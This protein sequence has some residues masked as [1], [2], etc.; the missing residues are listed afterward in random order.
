M[1][2]YVCVLWFNNYSGGR[3]R[4]RKKLRVRGNKVSNPIGI[5]IEK[6]KSPSK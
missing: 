5:L 1:N 3:E 2:F 4:E 6:N